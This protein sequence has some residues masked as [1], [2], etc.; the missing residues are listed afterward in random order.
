ML[1]QAMRLLWS[2]RYEDGVGEDD[3][4]LWGFVAFLTM[5]G[6]G[7]REPKLH[8]AERGPSGNGKWTPPGLSAPT[9]P[10]RFTAVPFDKYLFTATLPNPCNRLQ[11]NGEHAN[12]ANEVPTRKRRSPHVAN[13]R[14]S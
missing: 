11:E 6:V 13:P 9:M 14:H 4:R 1:L 10:I 7:W 12:L 3:Y 8:T 2:Y 5:V